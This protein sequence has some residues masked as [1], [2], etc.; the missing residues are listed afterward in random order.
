[1]PPPARY[2]VVKVEDYSFAGRSRLSLRV[3]ILHPNPSWEQVQ[4]ALL[5]AARSYPADAVLVFGHWPGD[6]TDSLYTAGRLE[7]G[8]NGYGWAGDKYLGPTGKFDPGSVL[9]PEQEEFIRGMR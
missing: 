3:V 1:M 6:D 9:T 5:A 8:K 2:Q 4:S 7:W